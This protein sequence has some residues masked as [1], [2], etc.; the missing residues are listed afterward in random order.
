MRRLKWASDFDVRTRGGRGEEAT[1]GRMLRTS[2]RKM[3][4]LEDPPIRSM[5]K[6]PKT[7]T[8]AAEEDLPGPPTAG[9]GTDWY[10]EDA[11]VRVWS[12]K[13]AIAEPSDFSWPR[14]T[15]MEFAAV[16]TKWNVDGVIREATGRR[17]AREIARE[18]LEGQRPE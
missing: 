3:Q 10:P 5:R 13:D 6:L 14:C 12:R 7:L 16:W 4:L 9:E 8:P 1:D 2:A 17:R 15:K 18:V 11:T